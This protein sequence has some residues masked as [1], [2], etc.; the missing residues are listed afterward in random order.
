[1]RR[2]ILDTNFLLIPMQFKVDIFSEIHRICD[3]QYKLC[4]F[5][6]TIEEL[7]AI[8]QKQKGKSKKAAQFALKLIRLKGIE[9]I[10]SEKSDVDYL[11]LNNIDDNTVVATQDASLRKESVKKE[12]SVIYLRN[13]KYLVLNERKPW[14]I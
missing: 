3:F 9:V 11:I 14:K 1:M 13:K 5:D 10:K 6:Q 7:R 4:V 12:A 8:M 2:I